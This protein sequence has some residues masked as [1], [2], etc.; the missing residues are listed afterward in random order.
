MNLRKL[1]HS[2]AASAVIAASLPALA[3]SISGQVTD[4]TGSAPLQG[5]IVSIDGLN[6]SS[7]TD[8]FGDYRIANVP[9][10]EY[11]V[12]VDYV[13]ANSVTQTVTVPASGAT[14]DFTIGADVRYLD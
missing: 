3:D 7:T 6:R 11:T 1:A 8:Q 13:G 12:I 14:A 9:A 5:A 4:S 2:S 10:G